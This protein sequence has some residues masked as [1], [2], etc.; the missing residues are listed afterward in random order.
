MCGFFLWMLLCSGPNQMNCTIFKLSP[1]MEWAECWTKAA[2]KQEF[3]VNSNVGNFKLWCSKH[4]YIEEMK[5]ER[6]T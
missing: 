5:S 1:R 4:D 6:R 3:L 2:E